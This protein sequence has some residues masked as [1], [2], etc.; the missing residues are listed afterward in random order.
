MLS[1]V[2]L[3]SDA[4]SAHTQ[5]A[6]KIYKISWSSQQSRHLSVETHWSLLKLVEAAQ[7]GTFT[8]FEAYT[9]PFMNGGEVLPKEMGASGQMVLLQS[10][11]ARSLD[12]KRCVMS[13][14][15]FKRSSFVL[16]RSLF[17]P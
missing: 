4:C 2:H 15:I 3:R 11:I 7:D 13:R 17:A 12:R 5:C 9:Y 10:G 14:T 16:C 1:F 8:T 6:D